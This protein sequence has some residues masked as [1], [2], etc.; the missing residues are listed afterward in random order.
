VTQV[1]WVD[2]TGQEAGTVAEPV[3]WQL[4]PRLSPDGRRISLSSNGGGNFEGDIWILDPERGNRTRLTFDGRDDIN[5]AWSPDG[6]QLAICAIAPSPGLYLGETGG[7][8]DVRPWWQPDSFLTAATWLANGEGVL[9]EL[10]GEENQLDLWRVPLP[11]EGEPTPFL[12]TPFGE[13]DAEVSP[14]GRWVAYTSDSSGRD[15]VYVRPT[16]GEGEVWTISTAGGDDPAWRRDGR[17]L[18]FVDAEGRLAVV[19]TTI[20]P[21]FSKGSPVV[22]FDARLEEVGGIRQ[23]DVAP[24]GQRFIVS[25]RVPGDDPIVVVMGWANEIGAR[26]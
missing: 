15:E 13:H 23:Y 25:R 21:S 17:E 14:D 1:V 19:P 5:A 26:P 16:R 20:T 22:L 3:A 7:S 12:A 2:R 4:S 24:D 8:G 18:F 11:G 6:S 10:F 9:V